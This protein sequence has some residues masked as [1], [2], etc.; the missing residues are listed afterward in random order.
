MD[1]AVQLQEVAGGQAP[2]EGR[3]GPAA[4]AQVSASWGDGQQAERVGLHGSHRN[5][6]LWCYGIIGS[7]R[8]ASMRGTVGT[9]CCAMHRRQLRCRQGAAVRSPGCRAEVWTRWECSA[10][11]ATA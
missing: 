6:R 2:T 11:P 5:R 4:P 1:T 10:R 3:A 7:L 9:R 8:R